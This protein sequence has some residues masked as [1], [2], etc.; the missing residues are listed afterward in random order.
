MPTLRAEFHRLREGTTTRSRR[1][2]GSSVW[3]VFDG[4]GAMVVDGE[5]RELTRGDLVIVPSWIPWNIEAESQ[6]DLFRF[7]D[8]PIIEALGFARTRVERQE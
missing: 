2:V 4:T 5:R 1:E 8:A 6:L 7:S 3:Q